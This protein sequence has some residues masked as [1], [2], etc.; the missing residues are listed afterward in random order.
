[1]HVNYDQRAL[2]NKE[3][4]KNASRQTINKLSQKKAVMTEGRTME[5]DFK[6]LKHICTSKYSSTNLQISF[7]EFIE[8]VK[9][10]V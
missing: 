3:R 6:E 2:I 8:I 1:M 5:Y 10:C 4:K 7:S 9:Y